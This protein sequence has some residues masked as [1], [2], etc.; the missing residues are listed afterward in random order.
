M[1]YTIRVTLVNPG[2][3]QNVEKTVWHY[4]NGGTWTEEPNG[5]FVL[6]MNG[7]GTSGTLRFKDSF[8]GEAFLAAFG[9]HNYKR[10]CDII[11]DLAENDTGADIHP[12]YYQ[13]GKRDNMLWQQAANIE[14]TDAKRVNRIS[15]KY[16]V[17]EGNNLAA[18]LT[19][20]RL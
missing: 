16:T 20:L 13:S 10:W 11:P 8:S 7:S 15:I 12:T 19:I 4:A 9:V 1:S 18:T 5:V 6:R 2:A 3:F 17:A 14:K